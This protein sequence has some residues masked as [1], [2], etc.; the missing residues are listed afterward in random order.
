MTATNAAGT[1]PDSALLSAA[2]TAMTL[3]P[4][5]LPAAAQGVAYSQT[6]SVNNAPP[7][8]PPYHFDVAGGAL[9]P[10]L[11][12]SSN[13]STGMIAG[14]PTAS[15]TFQFTI[16]VRLVSMPHIYVLQDYTLTV[17]AAAAPDA[18]TGVSAVAGT[19]QA[20]VSFTAPAND[21][22]ATI[23]GY[24]VTA[25]DGTTATGSASPIMVTG[26]TNGAPY[27]FTVKAINSVGASQ[28]SAASN[29]V[30]PDVGPAVVS[31][32]V[33][34]NSIYRVDDHLDF[35]VRWDQSVTVTGMPQIALVIGATVVQANFVSS[36]TATTTLFRYT[37]LPGQAD[38]NGI[39][40]GALT[41]N[42]GSIH[43]GAGIDAT[44]T[45][46]SVASTQFVLVRADIPSAPIIGTATAG[47]ASATVSFAPPASSG[48]SPIISYTGHC[49]L[50]RLIGTGSSQPDHGQLAS[51]MAR[52]TLSG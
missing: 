26:L 35:T 31:V 7:P 33:P 36:P 39:T 13:F 9:P 37:V 41:L 28:P 11:S 50:C 12:L 46:N 17:N 34:A 45:L 38:N 49:Q 6:L 1:S 8:G 14:T 15:G 30:T 43:S 32:S 44:L 2:P 10:G 25:S 52:L 16:R 22:G 47:D 29:S 24:E 18:P 27:T 3:S 40:M 51:P 19:G 23:T 48:G 21:G 42:G 20:T 5:T 4:A